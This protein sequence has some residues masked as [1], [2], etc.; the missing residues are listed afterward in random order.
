[1]KKIISLISPILFV[2]SANAGI[3]NFEVECSLALPFVKKSKIYAE[4]SLEEES[5]SLKGNFLVSTKDKSQWSWDDNPEM[6]FRGVLDLDS[7]EPRFNFID[8]DKK[9]E[10]RF[11]SIVPKNDE[12]YSGVIDSRGT[13]FP[14]E[15][16]VT[17]LD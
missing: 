6:F 4:F 1:M 2:L 9:H 17:K 15:C 13:F 10:I 5:R 7:G 14:T 11:I 3:V 12:I 8:L 16:E